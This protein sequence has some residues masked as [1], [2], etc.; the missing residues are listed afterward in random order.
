MSSIKSDLA[1]V[2]VVRDTYLDS[3]R[4]LVAT[5]VMSEQDGVARARSIR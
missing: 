5:S 3:L 2:R 1:R 4:L